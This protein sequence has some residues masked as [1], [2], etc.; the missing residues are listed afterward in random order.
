MGVFLAT[1]FNIIAR[2][3]ARSLD[4]R[5]SVKSFRPPS[6]SDRV[7]RQHPR[8]LLISIPAAVAGVIFFGL[9]LEHFALPEV[10]KTSN[11]HP[12]SLRE[13]SS[14]NGKRKTAGNRPIK[15]PKKS[16][17]AAIFV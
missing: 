5:T 14:Q 2:E 10:V 9:R 3:I 15:F 4:R 1:V 12:A 13:H 17:L 6:G 7:E 8:P 11:S 16:K